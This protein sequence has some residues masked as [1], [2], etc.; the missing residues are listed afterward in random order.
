MNQAFRLLTSNP[1]CK[2]IAIHRA[3]YY[4]ETEHQ[5]SLGPGPFVTALEEASSVQAIVVGKPEPA[6]FQLA[7]DSMACEPHQVAVIGDDVN[8]DVGQGAKQLGLQCYLVKT[9]KYRPGD[10]V[11]SNV[12]GVFD[13]VAQAIWHL[14]PQ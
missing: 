12:D 14:L 10:E 5:L 11:G 2:L 1:P 9:G 4:A 3:K 7:L 13:N 6:F 8:L